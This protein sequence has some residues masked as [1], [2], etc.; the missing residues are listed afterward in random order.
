MI[1]IKTSEFIKWEI[2]V[3]RD[4]ENELLKHRLCKWEVLTLF[5]WELLQDF[6]NPTSYIGTSLSRKHCI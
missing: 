6:K 5:S 2:L 3:K 1:I 4:I